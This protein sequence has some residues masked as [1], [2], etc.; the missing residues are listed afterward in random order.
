MHIV[1]YS[2]DQGTNEAFHAL[3]GDGTEIMA[4]MRQCIVPEERED[5]NACHRGG[6]ECIIKRDDQ[7]KKLGESINCRA[8]R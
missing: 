2:T 5:C 7:R 6:F 8:R 3:T 1:P 4:D